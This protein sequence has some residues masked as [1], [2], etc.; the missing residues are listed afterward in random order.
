ME[1]VPRRINGGTRLLRY[2][3]ARGV[4]TA[5][6]AEQRARALHDFSD[7]AARVAIEHG[8]IDPVHLDGL[9]GE[10]TEGGFLARAV[11]KGA[12]DRAAAERISVVHALREMLAAA[13]SLA[14]TG[15]LPIKLLIQELAAFLREVE[16]P[17][18]DTQC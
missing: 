6:E 4:L 7:A 15:R 18:Y 11:E 17:R 5:L 12:I 8:A 14:V 16:L 1:S 9:L 3:A 2:L 10:C 13:E